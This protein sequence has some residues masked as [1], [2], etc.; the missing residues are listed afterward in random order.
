M[1]QYL[2]EQPLSEADIISG[3][4]KRTL[5][6]EIVPALGGSAFKNKG[7]QAMLDAV[8]QYLP[9]P[10]DIKPVEG[11]TDGGE[12]GLRLAK[13]SAPF[14]ALAFKIASDPYVGSLTFMRVYSGR[15][16]SGS[17]V[18]NSAKQKRERIGRMVQMHSNLSLIHI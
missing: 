5:N 8:I 7:I 12:K 2:D 3:L 13:D 11:Y 17:T 10:T 16:E 15:L 4:R 9:S 14:A 18:Y 6:N 1:T